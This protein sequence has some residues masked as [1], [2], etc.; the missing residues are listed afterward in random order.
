[1]GITAVSS[2]NHAM[3]AK[4]RTPPPT[5]AVAVT[6]DVRALQKTKN[7][8]D[9]ADMPGGTNQ[10]GS[11]T[12]IHQ[13]RYPKSCVQNPLGHLS[14]GFYCILVRPQCWAFVRWALWNRQVLEATPI[15][16]VWPIKRCCLESR[17]I[18]IAKQTCLR[19]A[20]SSSFGHFFRMLCTP[21]LCRPLM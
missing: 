10:S 19:L 21:M 9:S 1:M 16:S 18:S 15:G 14:G 11:G 8:A 2:I 20:F 5:P 6:M 7:P 17:R 12:S 3:I 4:S 13:P